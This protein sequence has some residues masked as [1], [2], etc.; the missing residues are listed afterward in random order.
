LENNSSAQFA[1]VLKQYCSIDANFHMLKY[2]GRSFYPEQIL[3]EVKKLKKAHYK[4]DKTIVVVEKEDL[5]YYN[6]SKYGL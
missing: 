2:D 3:E 1:G 6:P 5:E 4:G